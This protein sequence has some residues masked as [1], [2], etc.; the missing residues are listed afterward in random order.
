MSF[1]V[2]ES[3][4][5]ELVITKKSCLLIKVKAHGCYTYSLLGLIF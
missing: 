4:R 2:T 5:I 1:E 3:S